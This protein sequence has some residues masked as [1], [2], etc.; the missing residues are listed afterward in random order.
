MACGTSYACP[1]SEPDGQ[2]F[3]RHIREVTTKR[4]QTAPNR[5]ETTDTD[6]NDMENDHV[7]KDPGPDGRRPA[8][9]TVP[10]K[11]RLSQHPLPLTALPINPLT[12]KPRRRAIPH[13][14]ASQNAGVTAMLR[15]KTGREPAWLRRI[16]LQQIK[17]VGRYTDQ[18]RPIQDAIAMGKME[19]RWDS[20]TLAQA[21][22]EGVLSS[23]ENGLGGVSEDKAQR[24]NWEEAHITAVEGLH[25]NHQ[26]RLFTQAVK[27]WK[28]WQI[29]KREKWMA[30]KEGI[31]YKIASAIQRGQRLQDELL[32]LAG[33]SS[34]RVKARH[35]SENGSSGVDW[36][37]RSK[38]TS[39]ELIRGALACAPLM[40]PTA[41]SEKVV[42]REVPGYLEKP[43]TPSGD[44][45]Q[46]LSEG[47]RKQILATL[48]I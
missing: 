40:I 1:P 29:V 25:A 10:G 38:E 2:Y 42:D 14:V 28:L 16:Q 15:Y 19:D 36:E 26:K 31:P 44:A 39:K 13:L 45:M 43:L 47:D 5:H 30:E 24:L 34:E 27:G 12:G 48:E 6:S 7:D 18:V 8:K 35:G 3:R 41:W 33:T 32:K 4:F 21:Q 22:R 9:G 23:S 46:R 11:T 20:D 17:R 37:I